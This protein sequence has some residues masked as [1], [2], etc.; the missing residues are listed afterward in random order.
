MYGRTDDAFRR[1]LTRP[2][3]DTIDDEDELRGK[4]V[5]KNVSQKSF[6]CLLIAILLCTSVTFAALWRVEVGKVANTLDSRDEVPDVR[7][8]L[9]DLYFSTNS[10]RTWS[11]C[12]ANTCNE[13]RCQG[14]VR[15]VS[16]EHYCTWKCVTCDANQVVTGLFLAH[17]HMSGTVPA[18]L[19]WISSLQTLDVSQN[20]HL[21]GTL[22][23]SLGGSAALQ[24]LA[25]NST[26][27][28]GTLPAALSR[29]DNL[30]SVMAMGARLSGTIPAM[31]SL[32]TLMLQRQLG[33][34]I[35]GT[36]PASRWPLEAFHLANN[37]LSGTLPDSI[38]TTIVDL[39][40]NAF[41][42]GLPTSYTDAVRVLKISCDAAPSATGI[43]VS[44]GG[45]CLSGTLPE[46]LGQASSLE[47]LE[48]VNNGLSGSLPAA[49]FSGLRSLTTL[50]LRGNDIS[51][52]VPDGLPTCA[53]PSCAC[54]LSGN[55]FEPAKVPASCEGSTPG[56]Q[57]SSSCG[58]ATPAPTPTPP[59]DPVKPTPTPTP[60]PI[61]PTPTPAH[62]P[63]PTPTPTTAPNSEEAAEEVQSAP[64]R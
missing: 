34:R 14:K 41:T 63:M 38:S 33:S 53:A 49:V 31:A 26:Q 51:G 18:S 45:G 20:A 15:W 5:C 17:N 60:D 57:P 9:I 8:A 11:G 10:N 6:M 7:R 62:T 47:W 46:G 29:A 28:S 16:Q 27:I 1:P 39:D 59:V 35:S 22:P 30:R 43:R 3:V 2:I 48:L 54:D 61:T 32:R 56:Q 25:F 24:T 40:A 55:C 36:L 50:D 19:T 58:G 52:A 64:E 23:A 21:A 42:G 44:T 12:D 4:C 37:R 13:A